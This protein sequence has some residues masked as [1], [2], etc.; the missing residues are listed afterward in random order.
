MA[1]IFLKYVKPKIWAYRDADLKCIYSRAVTGTSDWPTDGLEVAQGCPLVYNVSRTTEHE[2]RTTSAYST[3]QTI[4]SIVNFPGRNLNTTRV[5]TSWFRGNDSVRRFPTSIHTSISQAQ[6]IS[7]RYAILLEKLKFN[8]KTVLKFPTF[9]LV[10]IFL[11][12]KVWIY[13]LYQIIKNRIKV[14]SN[15]WI[16]R[17]LHAPKPPNKNKVNKHIATLNFH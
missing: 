8:R 15:S 6:Q 2:R 10:I 7:V 5:I 11:M 9:A 1:A 4:H 16:L 14:V 12:R 3:E 13:I 17:K